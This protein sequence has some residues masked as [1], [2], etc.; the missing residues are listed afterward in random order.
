MNAK[1]KKKEKENEKEKKERKEL[2]DPN[3]HQ[4]LCV[5]AAHLSTSSK[6][7]RSTAPISPSA[8]KTFVKRTPQSR[9]PCFL[10]PT[11]WF[12]HDLS[13]G[14]FK[15]PSASNLRRASSRAQLCILWNPL[16][17]RTPPPFGSRCPP[18]IHPIHHDP[19]L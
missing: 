15:M 18:R 10:E 11:E 13:S 5:S 9:N 2:S 8:R 16:S 6:T 19:R 4:S 12:F 14:S 17:A 3:Q 7:T 1:E